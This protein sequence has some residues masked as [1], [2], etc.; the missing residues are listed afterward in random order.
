MFRNVEILDEEPGLTGNDF[1]VLHNR[2]R[3][4]KKRERVRSS[5]ER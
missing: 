1:Y 3:R 4:K 2:R 5:R